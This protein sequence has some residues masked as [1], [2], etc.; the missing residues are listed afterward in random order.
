VLELINENWSRARDKETR[1]RGRGFPCVRLVQVEYRPVELSAEPGEQRALPYG[2]RPGKDH[3][4][5]LCYTQGDNFEEPP[6][7]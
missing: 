7:A 6:G 5:F 1:I 4:R 2:A 3:D